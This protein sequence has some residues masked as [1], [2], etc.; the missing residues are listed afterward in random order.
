MDTL[1]MAQAGMHVLAVD[2]DPTLVELAAANA[3]ELGLSDRVRVLRADLMTVDAVAEG[4]DT[5]FLDPARRADGRR[6]LDP[7]RWSPPFSRAVE[8]AQRTQR[9]V[10]KV[11]PGLDRALVPEGARFEA[12]SYG[13]RLVEAAIWF[14]VDLGG[15]ARNAV[16]L[17]SGATLDDLA[18][19]PERM[20]VG[21]WGSWLVEP[22]D[23]VI[24][25]GLVAQLAARFGGRLIDASIA[26]VTSDTEPPADPLY[27]RF[28]IDEVLP[29][30]LKALRAALRERR[31]GRVEVK[32]RGF[33]MDPDEV[34]RGLKLDKSAPSARTVLLTRVGSDPVAVIAHRR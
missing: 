7:E 29:F 31:V 4:C 24:R 32:K 11:A 28:E 8:L 14:G 20:P 26:Y 25:S 15:A 16:V 2:R 22:D 27:A 17:P 23:A 3:D 12:V 10:I 1:A 13:G 19:R 9:A 34:R 18:P 30:S 6:H 5:T 33:A 21:R